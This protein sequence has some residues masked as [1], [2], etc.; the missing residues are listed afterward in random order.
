MWQGVRLCVGMT[1]TCKNIFALIVV[2]SMGG[3]IACSPKPAPD[4]ADGNSVTSGATQPSPDTLVIYL[5]E[6]GKTIVAKREYGLDALRELLTDAL[7]KK[8]DTR[9]IIRAATRGER[10]PFFRLLDL[11]K[12]VGVKQANISFVSNG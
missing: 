11:C 12:R 2:A 6:S 10:E 8:P 1:R 5:D 9:V 4:G 3:P 7:A